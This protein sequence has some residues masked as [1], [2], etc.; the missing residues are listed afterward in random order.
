MDLI[1]VG[2]DEKALAQ[3]FNVYPNPTT[4]TITVDFDNAKFAIQ[5]IEISDARGRKVKTVF[6]ESVNG[7]LTVNLGDFPQ[8]LWLFTFLTNEGNFSKRVVKI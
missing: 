2:I 6:N 1:T 5:S 4:N 7:K 3:Q 8:G